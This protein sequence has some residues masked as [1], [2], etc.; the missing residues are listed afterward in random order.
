MHSAHLWP[1]STAPGLE[2]NSSAGFLIYHV[3]QRI[4]PV[5]ENWREFGFEIRFA[6]VV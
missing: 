1:K 6:L 2:P 4:L 3:V 5:S